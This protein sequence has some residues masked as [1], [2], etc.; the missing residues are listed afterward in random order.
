MYL[1]SERVTESFPPLL[2]EPAVNHAFST[3]KAPHVLQ[4]F[5]LQ[6]FALFWVAL[7][8]Q[9]VLICICIDNTRPTKPKFIVAH[10]AN[11][12][13]RN[14]DGRGG[15]AGSRQVRHQSKA[16]GT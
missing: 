2:T 8:G 15:W 7:G 3:N 6:H 16:R 4:A 5:L 13:I 14:M 1:T 12:H 11:M 10:I 9:L